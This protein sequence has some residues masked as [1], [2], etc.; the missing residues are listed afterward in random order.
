MLRDLFD[1]LHENTSNPRRIPHGGNVELSRR[2]LSH[3][4]LPGNPL[5][6]SAGPP[7]RNF[8]ITASLQ[9]KEDK[10]SRDPGQEGLR[11]SHDERRR[12]EASGFPFTG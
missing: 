9:G 11:N 6:F 12:G 1:L 8:S 7:P 3:S 5:P 2:G 10:D 4:W